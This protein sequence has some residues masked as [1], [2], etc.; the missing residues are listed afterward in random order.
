MADPPCD[1]QES[2]FARCASYGVTASACRC[3]RVPDAQTFSMFRTSVPE[4]TRW[5]G[6]GL[7]QQY[8][9]ASAS[10]LAVGTWRT[11]LLGSRRLTSSASSR[12][13]RIVFPSLAS[14]ST[15]SAQTR[16]YKK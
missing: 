2:A 14:V 16:S 5:Y 13:V 3:A 12:T 10:S 15:G 1:E 4:L 7:L 6:A 9:F 11:C 8:L